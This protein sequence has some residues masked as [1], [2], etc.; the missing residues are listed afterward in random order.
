MIDVGFVISKEEDLALGSGT[1]LDHSRAFVYQSFIT[2]RKDRE[3]SDID[4]R[5]QQ[6]V[7]PRELYTFSIC[8][9]SKSKVCFKVVKVLPDT[10]PQFTS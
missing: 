1:R 2:V 4:I 9:Y 3:I 7:L 10:L 8:Y 5:R 6:R